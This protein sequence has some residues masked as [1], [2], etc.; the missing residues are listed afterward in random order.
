M[1]SKKL[2]GDAAALAKEDVVSAPIP[3]AAEVRADRLKRL[4]LAIADGT[5]RI[6]ADEI[7]D[8][9]VDLFKEKLTKS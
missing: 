2:P 8:K 9:V 6:S 4:K 3:P 1:R 5:Y 7:A